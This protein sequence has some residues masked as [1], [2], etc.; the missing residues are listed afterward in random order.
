LDIEI[1]QR[2]DGVFIY[3]KKYVQNI[4]LKFKMKNY[5]PVNTSSLVNEKLV[6]DDGSGDADAVQYRSLV[7]N[8][9]YLT[10]T[11]LNIMYASGLL[12]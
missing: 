1:D 4:L 5:N 10:T 11:R 7:E 9:L 8:L 12:S 3:Q 2:E 6:K